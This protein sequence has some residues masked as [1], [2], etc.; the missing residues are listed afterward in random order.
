MIKY[1]EKEED[2]ENEIDKECIL[3]D[4]FATWC[5]PCKMLNVTLEDFI[6]ENKEFDILK[7]DIDKFETLAQKYGVMSVPTLIIFKNK[8]IIKKE[9]GFKDIDSLKDMINCNEN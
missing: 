5:G 1:L 6:K 8:E 4:F 3:V 7:V 2:F 9:I